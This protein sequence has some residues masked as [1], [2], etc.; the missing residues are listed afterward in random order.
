MSGWA[1]HRRVL[2]VAVVVLA[3]S[4]SVA[5]QPS[6]FLDWL[7]SD[8]PALGRT[9][10]G[11]DTAW[12]AGS[13]AF[14]IPTAALDAQANG[15][16]RRMAFEG[17]LLHE[18]LETTNHLGGPE[19]RWPIMGL[20]AGSL[21]TRSSRF[22]D[23]AFTSLQGWAY[24]GVASYGIK[25]LVGRARPYE[26]ESAFSFEPLSGRSSFPS[27]HTTSAFAIV[28]PWVLYYRDRSPLV[29]GLFALPVGT[30]MARME[31]DK[32][33]ISDVVAGA[34]LGTATSVWLT[35]RHL[36]EHPRPPRRVRPDV[37]IGPRTVALRATF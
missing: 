35:R 1:I 25:E 4:A 5:A 2:T 32:H 10:V 20:F 21:L 28:T 29:W 6:R 13:I 15:Q 33:W 7:A 11:S 23:A 14:L 31:R 36:A 8:T 12:L 9:I 27:G 3:T 18:V 16:V 34:A 26:S 24:A 22:Q 17:N 19:A 30:A 37:H